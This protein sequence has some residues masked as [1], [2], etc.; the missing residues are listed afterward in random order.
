MNQERRSIWEFFLDHYRFT[1]VI[2]AT[3]VVLGFF[4]AFT[5]PKEANPEIDFPVVVI[6]TPFPGA[7]PQE[8]EEL[9]TNR[10]EDK[11]V[12]L[13]DVD[14]VT[15]TSRTGLSVVTILF[16]VDADSRK[17]LEDTKDKVDE[18]KIELPGDAEDPIVQKVSFS[19]IP[20]L[21]FSLSGPFDLAQMTQ[22]AEQLEAD[23]ERVSGVSRVEIA[24]DLVREIRILIDK[25]QLDAY[26]LPLAQVTNALRLSNTDIP[27]GA[28]ET[29]GEIFPLR[30]AG[31]VESAEEIKRI[32]IAVRG[33]VPVFVQDVGTVI[34]GYREQRTISRLS[35]KGEE[36]QQSV[37]LSVFSVAGA[38]VVRTV[39]TIREVIAAAQEEVLPE[40]VV[41]VTAVDNA[42]LIRKDLGNLLVN[43]LETIAIVMVLLFIFLGWREAILAGLA[44]PLTFLITFSFLLFRG[45]TFNFLTLFSLILSLGILVDSAIVVTEAIH[46]ALQEGKTPREAAAETIREFQ[47]PL[48][49]G[50]FT[51]IFAFLP[52]ILT[53]GILGKFIE[54]IPITVTA[55]LLSSLF[56]ALGIVTTLSMRFLKGASEA[57]RE[58][59]LVRTKNSANTTTLLERLRKP[60]LKVL[61][62]YLANHK[63]R[64]NF[65]IGIIFLFFAAL[66]LPATG[67]LSVELFN[68]SDEDTIYIEVEHP[69]GTPLEKSDASMRPIEDILQAEKRFPSFTTNIGRSS[70]ISSNIDASSVSDSHLAHVIVNLDREREQESGEIIDEYQRKL[71]GAI[72]ADIQV[73]QLGAGPG[74][75][76]PVEVRITG[77]ELTVI[78]DLAESVQKMLLA[79]PGT[80]NVEKS[81]QESNGELVMQIDRATAQIYGLSA[82]E[83]ALTLRNAITG[84]KATELQIDQNDVDVVVKYRLN[85]D[86][87]PAA[88]TNKVNVTTIEGLTIPTQQGDIPLGS[89]LESTLENSRSSIQHR[90]GKRIVRVTSLVDD[91]T[92]TPQKVFQEFSRQLDALFIPDG[93]SVELGGQ[94]EDITE[95]F[96]DMLRALLLGVLLIA[97]LLVWQFRS[98]RQPFFIIVTIPLGL[99][100]VFFG[101]T[102]VGLPLSF[103]GVIGVVALAGIVVNNAIIL[104][105]RINKNRK[106][107]LAED[108]AISRACGERLQPIIL[109]TITTVSGIL[110]L[111]I[112][113]PVWGPLG[114]SIVFGLIFS[115]VLTLL[116]VPLLYQ[117]F[118]E[119]ELD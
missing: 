118:A 52:M 56:V 48:I 112:T 21:T 59:N 88:T 44:I 104:I 42:E 19:D 108:S 74:D 96:S 109:T 102:A 95:S 65:F 24:G 34:D 80:R 67:L 2:I 110:P 84:T 114:Y 106:A 32:P 81:V 30:F 49:T 20:F 66:A 92:T 6:S 53:G 38:D 78:D 15:S 16:D 82:Q 107:G 73:I 64:R 22:F 60:Y 89:F 76:A 90:D 29:A 61:N 9:V 99:I 94:R 69:V 86:E 68:R 40:G 117:K 10:I 36:P 28:I 47:V 12:N 35:V 98:Y 13:E 14:E 63:K 45:D 62:A 41:V 50:T 113:N 54:T 101:L 7:S 1:M 25:A 71:E 31:R 115:T 85:D 27:A 91:A 33:D 4:A 111:A 77:P 26:N 103:P 37:S 3:I 100:G 23:V 57:A 75:I 5:L 43:G 39:D 17:T 87:A 83:I 18:A 58:Q 70:G 72:D 8:V 51:T 93:Y 119:K 105:D 11:V 46:I 79:I 97:A 116:V 55:I